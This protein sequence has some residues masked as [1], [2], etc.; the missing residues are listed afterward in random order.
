MLK[1][2][3]PGIPGV[4]VSANVPTPQVPQVPQVPHVPTPEE[5]AAMAGMGAMSQS[6]GVP[7]E[8]QA[9]MDKHNAGE[10]SDEEFAAEVQKL[11]LG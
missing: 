11:N 2:K 6:T 9:L 4:S 7:P 10:I 5:L 1:P 8:L 3:L